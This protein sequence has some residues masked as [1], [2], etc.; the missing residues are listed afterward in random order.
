MKEH[1]V[2]HLALYAGILKKVERQGWV[3][4]GIHDPESVADHTFRTAFLAMLLVKN[5]PQLDEMRIMKMA[6]VHEMGE[7]IIGDVVYE[8][9]ERVIA[10][11]TNKYKDERSAWHTIFKNIHDSQEYTELWEEWAAQKTP[12]AKFL[13][14]VEKLEMAIQA[15]E[16]EQQ[17]YDFK[18]L[19]EFWSNAQKYII[20]TSIEPTF[21]ELERLRTSL[22]TIK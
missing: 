6:L 21:R 1:E 10:P 20:G 3:L 19:E 16:Y 2:I 18:L 17:G 12:E 9:G 11:V 8:H 22:K 14:A 7:A 13:K 4:K 15:Y 5:E